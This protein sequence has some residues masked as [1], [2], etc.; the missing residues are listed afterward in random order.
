VN[1][2]DELVR[3]V[4]RLC[5]VGDWDGLLELRD[6]ARRAYEETG[7]QL[8]PA[9]TLAEYRLA[10]EA[11][12][13]MAARVL[14][15]GAGHLGLGPIPEVVASTHTWHELAPHVVPG[16]AAWLA[17][18]ERVVRGEDLR[19]APVGEV[20]E[21]PLVLADWEPVYAVP[22]YRPDKVELIGPP[23]P[24]LAT[25]PRQL[26]GHRID[27][28][29]VLPALKALV[30]RW[31]VE[32]GGRVEVIAVEGRAEDAAACL[33]DSPTIGWTD[34]TLADALA[35]MA[36]AA[37]SGGAHGRRRGAAVGRFDTW[38]A[39][40]ALTGLL[41]AWPVDPDELGEAADELRW[42]LWHPDGPATGW[43]LHLA[44]EDPADG[45]AWAIAAIDPT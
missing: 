34:T 6:H 1:D 39:V 10:L 40:A 28:T 23:A 2:L 13:E 16:P 42:C 11:P 32:S 36:W 31:V 45:L 4:D 14:V 33:T 15:E 44:V 30:E 41:D 35:R 7:H 25:E 17:A 43:R 21:L 9:A 29:D 38:W 26:P 24:L 22:T 12:A 20:L 8:W 19:G 5:A 18:H 3:Q 27:D 37:A